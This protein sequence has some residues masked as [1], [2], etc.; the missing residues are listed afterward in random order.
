MKPLFATAVV[1][2]Q[3]RNLGS[4]S[5][6]EKCY[7]SVMAKLNEC[8]TKSVDISALYDDP[9]ECEGMDGAKMEKWGE[10]NISKA[11]SMKKVVEVCMTSQRPIYSLTI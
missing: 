10:K 5:Q 8:Q 9:E 2:S 3:G 6:E 11:E 1:L 7:D 4:K